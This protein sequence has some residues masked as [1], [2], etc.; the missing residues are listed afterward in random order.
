MFLVLKVS[1]CLCGHWS[2]EHL[3]EWVVSAAWSCRP[4]HF[5][6]GLSFCQESWLKWQALQWEGKKCNREHK[7]RPSSKP[8]QPTSLGLLPSPPSCVPTPG[9]LVLPMSCTAPARW[10]EGSSGPISGLLPPL[11]PRK[12]QI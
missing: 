11:R 10:E 2:V 6:N 7:V 12:G 1:N 3:G 8:S 9:L 4:H 5:I